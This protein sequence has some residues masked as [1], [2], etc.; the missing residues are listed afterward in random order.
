MNILDIRLF[1]PLLE[2]CKFLNISDLLTLSRS[3][4]YLKYVV[5]FEIKRRI[6]KKNC[7][8]QFCF[9]SNFIE[10]SIIHENGNIFE[11]SDFNIAVKLFR[12]YGDLIT[13]TTFIN[14]QFRNVCNSIYQFTSNY[15]INQKNMNFLIKLLKFVPN[16][17]FFWCDVSKLDINFSVI[18][19]LSITSNN[20]LELNLNRF[21]NLKKLTINISF[22]SLLNNSHAKHL[23]KLKCFSFICRNKKNIEF[24][25]Q[26]LIL[27]PQIETIILNGIVENV[28]DIINKYSSKLNLLV[29]RNISENLNFSRTTT[30]NIDVE[31]LNYIEIKC[32]NLTKMIITDHFVKYKYWSSF[33]NFALQIDFSK[34][35]KNVIDLT[36]D[37]C[38]SQSLLYLPNNLKYLNL[39]K[40]KITIKEA[41][42]LKNF[43]PS[44][45]VLKSLDKIYNF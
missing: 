8:V 36:L 40:Q 39:I 33:S 32:L 9:F 26:M 18:K 14:S 27:N 29:C 19:K 28:N 6:F 22:D 34:I 12:Y 13:K 16:F 24:L 37:V 4:I 2:V 5:E 20:L 23:P 30:L 11:I 35:P 31:S 3:C 17:N 43:I 15:N 10:V 45:L 25:S 42:I 7:N 1:D 21:Q 44:L 41:N 38:N